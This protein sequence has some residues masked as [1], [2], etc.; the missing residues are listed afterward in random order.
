MLFIKNFPNKELGKIFDIPDVA[1]SLFAPPRPTEKGEKGRKR[2]KKDEKRRK[3]TRRH[4]GGG[5]YYDSP[6]L[7]FSLQEGM[8]GGTPCEPSSILT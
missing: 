1:S 8:G 3:K 4:L 6:T 5:L 2:T 7:G